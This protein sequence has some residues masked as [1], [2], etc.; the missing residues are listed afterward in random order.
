M[1]STVHPKNKV[2]VAKRPFE[3]VFVVLR[4]KNVVFH[5]IYK[6]F[7]LYFDNLQMMVQVVTLV[8]FHPNT[9]KGGCSLTVAFWSNV[10]GK[11]CVTSNLA[12]MSVL[13]TLASQREGK[14]ILLENHQN[15]FNLG[16]VLFSQKSKQVMKERSRYQVECGLAQLLRLLEQGVTP[17][18]ECFYHITEDFLGKRLFY[19]STEGVHNTDIFEY[20]MERECV[21]TMH[22][23][24][25]QGELVMIDTSSAPL[26]SS[27][28]ILQE[29]DLVVVNLNQNR[30]RIDH[31]FRN[32]SEIRRKAFYLIGDYDEES[33][34]SKAAIMDKYDVPGNR[35]G[36]IPHNIRFADA[37][38]DGRLIPFLLRNYECVPE[39]PN[40]RFMRAAKESVNLFCNQLESLYEA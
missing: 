36:T 19:L 9:K 10:G 39:N 22:Y 20:K 25:N 30:Q 35:I 40:Y 18:E 24:E 21:R 8:S 5:K 14:T 29:A 12:C 7:L 1:N 17:S 37:V 15:I 38:S 34:F 26:P 23:L 11:S 27:R 3:G 31:F 13:S 2:H 6:I 32:Y 4:R 28:K 16:N 33:E